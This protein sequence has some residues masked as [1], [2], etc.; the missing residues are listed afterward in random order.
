MSADPRI[1]DRLAKVCGLFG[2]NQVG[3]RAA[4]ADRAEKIRLQL[5]LSW[6]DLLKGSPR[7]P[8][9]DP[10]TATPAALVARCSPILTEWEKEFLA[11]LSGR[12]AFT[13]KQKNRLRIIRTKCATWYANG[14]RA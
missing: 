11:S 7:L 12:F 4:A 10:E 9:F 8:D 1:I 2:S 5:G 6:A 3:E 14:G 13:E